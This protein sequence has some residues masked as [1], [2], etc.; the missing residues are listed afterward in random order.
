MGVFA[1]DGVARR[2]HSDPLYGDDWSALQ[3]E[4][5][6]AYDQA[7]EGDHVLAYFS[8][9][10]NT[11][12]TSYDTSCENA[13][14][15]PCLEKGDMVFL[16]DGYYDRHAKQFLN[17]INFT[18]YLMGYRPESR[19]FNYLEAAYDEVAEAAGTSSTPFSTQNN[20]TPALNSPI[21]KVSTKASITLSAVVVQ[22][23]VL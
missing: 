2:V 9:Y 13:Q 23:P 16:I 5:N 4:T 19:D 22:N 8:Q 17:G 12:Y 15:T 20:P 14:T 1:T 3:A 21:S 7:S 18:D 10:S 6:T 11:V